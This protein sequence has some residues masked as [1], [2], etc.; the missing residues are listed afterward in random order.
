MS[1][2]QD[3]L[4]KLAR[5]RDAATVS[6][7]YAVPATPLPAHA[8]GASEPDTLATGAYTADALV[9]AAD[10]AA[11]AAAAAH[12][13]PDLGV[14]MDFSAAPD[15][16]AA[17][18]A[19][20]T[21]RTAPAQ[22][23]PERFSTVPPAR[24]DVPVL[25]PLDRSCRRHRILLEG[26]AGNSKLVKRN[27]SALAAYRMLRTRI[28]QRARAQSWTTI[29][30]TSP[31]AGE[32][33]SMTTLN[34]ALS[35]ARERNSNVFLLDLDMRNPSICRYLGVKP[36]HPLLDYFRGQC[37]VSD[38]FFSIGVENLT[39]AG[40]LTGTDQSSELLSTSLL[41]SLFA[42]IREHSTRPLILID[43]PPVLRNDDTLVV[44]PRVD[45]LLLVLAEGD[46]RRDAATRSIE[47]LHDYNI[48]G[49]VL[50]RSR[51]TMTG[52]YYS[53]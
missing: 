1:K 48:A 41:E 14:A 17:A 52:D 33:K 28:L 31:A 32:G 22:F 46:S 16:G 36:P 20:A 19:E 18:Q 10:P 29:A 13:A 45:A 27:A 50:N 2:I 15:L 5:A 26:S 12:A 23:T 35:I 51:T 43:L 21:A 47:V 30:V 38:T 42:E 3:A 24:F 6:R 4:Q 34:L 25:A 53:P 7:Q 39:L 11:Q 8:A 9:A 37:T 40:S 44:A 49:I